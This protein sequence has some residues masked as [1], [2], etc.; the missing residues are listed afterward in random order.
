MLSHKYVRSRFVVEQVKRIF[1]R[2]LTN[3]ISSSFIVNSGCTDVEIPHATLP[4]F[5]ST[6]YD[7]YERFTAVECSVTK[8][9]YTYG[10]IRSKST[11]LAKAFR[12]I[13]K[14]E[15]GDVVAIILKNIPEYPIADIG[16]M[17]ANLISSTVSPVFTS[18]EIA[19]QLIDSNAKVV[20]TDVDLSTT[21][22]KAVDIIAKKLPLLAIKTHKDQSLPENSI[23]FHELVNTKVDYPEIQPGNPDDVVFLPYSS[24]TT[25]LPKGV[26]LTHKNLLANM[27][28]PTHDNINYRIDATDSF[29]EHLPAVIPLYHVYGH[30]VVMHNITLCGGKMITLPGFSI[31]SYISMLKQYQ[32]NTIYFMAPPLFLLMIELEA[33][34]KEYLKNARVMSNGAAPLASSDELRFIEKFGD[35]LTVLQGYGLTETAPVVSTLYPKIME[36]VEVYRGSIGRPLPNTQIKIVDPEDSTNTPLGPNISGELLVK[37][38]QVMKGYLNLPEE[39]KKTI[40]EDGWLR[41]GDA[42]YYNEEGFMYIVDRYKELIKVRGN[43]VPPAELE[44]LIRTFPGVA[45]AAVIGIP[46][47]FSGELPRAYIVP[48][49]GAKVDT[50]S[51]DQFVSEKVTRYKKLEGGIVLVKEIPKNTSG[52]ILRKK[53]RDTYIAKGI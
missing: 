13:F 26:Q 8:R 5:L 28:Q 17:K 12:K 46:N 15:N 44:A 52:K 23:D 6:Y 19:R 39:T 18:D 21:V 24:G 51:L 1:K 20:I 11:N 45:D 25:G 32:N 4:E 9:K 35:H 38:P 49:A 2:K 33:V 10:E 50:K 42:S 7:K 34:K 30:N 48:K 16:I 41:T 53:I 37:G 3:N 29:Q 31:E 27:I 14:L 36:K 43:Q 22:K 47:K 40:T